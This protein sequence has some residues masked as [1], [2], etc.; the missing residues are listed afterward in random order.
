MWV[1]NLISG[2]ACQKKRNNKQVL[3]LPSEGEGAGYPVVA[4]LAEVFG[5][6][7]Y[8]DIDLKLLF[9]CGRIVVKRSLLR[10]SDVL[11]RCKNLLKKPISI[12]KRG[13]D[14]NNV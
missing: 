8:N 9:N 12:Q 11:L 10:V 13:V 6:E 2:P 5:A 14:Q 7:K 4:V 1:I 3:H